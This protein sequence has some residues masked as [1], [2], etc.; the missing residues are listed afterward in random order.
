MD[1]P[2][3]QTTNRTERLGVNA[4]AETIVRLG[5]IWRETPMADV[6]IDGQIEYVDK[7]GYVTGRMIAVQIKS[8]TSF[9]NE[10]GDSW[11]FYPEKKHRFY[12]ER[13]PLPVIIILHNPETNQS[14]W[15]DIRQSLRVLAKNE[16]GILVPKV[17]ILQNTDANTLFEGFAILNQGFMSIDEVLNHL[18]TTKSGN[19]SFPV[20]YF[21]LFCSGL[22]NIC[23]SLYFGMD[24]AMNIA[25]ENLLLDKSPFGV[26][27]GESEQE[28]LFNYIKFLVHQ[29]IADIDFSDCMIDWYERQMQ[30]TFM[31]PLTS[32]G[33]E[34]VSA[35]HKLEAKYKEEGSLPDTGYLHAA[36]E[37]FVHQVITHSEVQRI[38][39]MTNIEMLYHGILQGNFDKS[40]Q[41]F[42]RKKT[43]L[44]SDFLR[45]LWQT[46]NG[47]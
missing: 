21:S 37:S 45:R 2:K 16:K 18:I 47:G 4:V 22:T 15:Q 42:G 7:D 26:G 38:E 30:P 3:Y 17:N 27:V 23:R 44:R 9:F 34:L 6:G 12:W 19:G 33:K 36:Q 35:I 46:I 5:L 25:E 11:I 1:L 41:K 13:F 29:H 10:K 31:A 39:L 24:V 8:G 40:H 32:R 43:N 20:S 14:Y 28:F